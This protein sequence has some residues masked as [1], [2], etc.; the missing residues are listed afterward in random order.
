MK[1]Q[2]HMIKFSVPAKNSHRDGWI[3]VG[4]N[5]MKQ[6]HVD[7]LIAYNASGGIHDEPVIDQGSIV[8]RWGRSWTHASLERGEPGYKIGGEGSRTYETKKV[9]PGVQFRPKDDK[10]IFHVGPD[11]KMTHG[12]LDYPKTGRAY[13]YD[14]NHTCR[15]GPKPNS[16]SARLLGDGSYVWDDAK[17]FWRIKAA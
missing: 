5:P 11:G 8:G 15:S 3:Y 12:I 17:A 1:N 6:K 16:K 10:A 7:E 14:G 9:G 13:Y 2:S 4:L